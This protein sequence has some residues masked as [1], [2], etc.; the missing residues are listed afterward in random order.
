MYKRFCTYLLAVLYLQLVFRKGPDGPNFTTIPVLRVH[1]NN[2]GLL[3]HTGD[4]LIQGVSDDVFTVGS[5]LCKS[6]NT[7]E[8]NRLN[9]SPTFLCLQKIQLLNIFFF[10]TISWEYYG[11]FCGR[12]FYFYLLAFP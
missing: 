9:G 3:D 11:K 1:L 7:R 4:T 8:T 6:E 10:F 2:E 12:N 5:C